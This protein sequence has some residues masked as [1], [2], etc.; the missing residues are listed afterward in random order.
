MSHDLEMEQIIRNDFG[1]APQL[2]SR[3]VDFKFAD[4]EI[5]H[6][7]IK[8][9]HCN[10]NDVKFAIMECESNK[11]LFS[12][13]FY[14][15]NNPRAFGTHGKFKL[16]LVYVHDPSLRGLG[17]GTYYINKLKEYMKGNG[18]STLSIVA[19]SNADVF[20]NDN[21]V[22]TSKKDLIKYYK[23]FEDDDIKIEIINA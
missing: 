8:G 18:G 19:E 15:P 14:K 17:I 13:D 12:M 16:E 10:K 23:K 22:K 21:S 6:P 7:H 20:K 9:Y 3:N 2:C 4:E 11:T 5:N 1:I